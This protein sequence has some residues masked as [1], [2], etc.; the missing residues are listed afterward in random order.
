M[1][2]FPWEHAPFV[3]GKNGEHNHF[4]GI[5]IFFLGWESSKTKLE[6]VKKIYHK[7]SQLKWKG[8]TTSTC[9]FLITIIDMTPTKL[10]S[11]S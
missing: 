8:P 4:C 2:A 1:F 7:I 10:G 3:Q 6:M 11:Q 9:Q 5:T